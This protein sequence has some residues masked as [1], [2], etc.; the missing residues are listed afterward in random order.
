[1]ENFLLRI[2]RPRRG[3][4]RRRDHPHTATIKEFG[5]QLF[6]AVFQEELHECLMRSLSE[7]KPAP[8]SAANNHA[9]QEGG[10]LSLS[11]NN[12]PRSAAFGHPA[13]EVTGLHRKAGRACPGGTL[14]IP[15]R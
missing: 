1:M 8:A 3:G 9:V 7:V 10:L 5:G 6:A 4:T 14:A 2:G 12:G 11:S 13:G 15:A